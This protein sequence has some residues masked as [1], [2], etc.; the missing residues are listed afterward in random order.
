M[1]LEN[2]TALITG[3]SSGIGAALAHELSRCKMKCILVSLNNDALQQVGDSIEKETG[4]RPITYE[5]NVTDPTELAKV[6]LQLHSSLLDGLHL[7]LLNAFMTMHGRFECST[8]D[9]LLLKM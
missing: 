4:L 6:A 2:K 3:A 8:S 1:K 7:F 5:C 9:S